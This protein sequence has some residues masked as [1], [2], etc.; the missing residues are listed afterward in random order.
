MKFIPFIPS[1]PDEQKDTIK[2]IIKSFKLE[3]GKGIEL[4]SYI[5][6]LEQKIN[7]IDEQS[8]YGLSVQ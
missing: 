3:N 8:D 6:R 1:I 5:V 4:L 2:N 7:L